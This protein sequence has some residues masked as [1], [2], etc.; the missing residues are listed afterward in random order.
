MTNA[1]KKTQDT[2]LNGVNVTRLEATKEA[3]RQ[4]PAIADFRFRVN[5]KWGGGAYNKATITD[6]YG[7]KQNIAH[8]NALEIACDEPDILLGDDNGANPVEV[9]LAALSG[10]MTTSLTYHAAAQG[11][12]I[13][14]IESA[15]EGGI[16]LQGFLG[17]DE[18]MEKG[19]RDIQV[20]LKVKGDVPAEKV[21]E[22]A[23][24]S[25]V[26]DT[27]SRP[28]RINVKVEKA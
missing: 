18:R 28:I 15:L 11:Y 3:I 9:L 10:C 23:E 20:T 5:N 19:F 14:S 16:D 4:D 26:F 25:P 22:C 13:E 1:L 7:A 2:I 17:L 27:L 6:F 21:K 24:R 12:R 8:K